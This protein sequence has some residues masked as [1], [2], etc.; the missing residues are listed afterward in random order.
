MTWLLRDMKL[1]SRPDVIKRYAKLLYDANVVG[2]KKLAIKLSKNSQFLIEL[3]IDEDDAELIVEQTEERLEEEWQAKELQRIQLL[4][5]Q[6]QSCLGEDVG[7]ISKT[8]NTVPLGKN[9]DSGDR[10]TIL[11]VTSTSSDISPLSEISVA[12]GI[13]YK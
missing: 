1:E 8:S 13:S 5:Q 3:G 12:A 10:V 4:Q 11:P 7:M 2:Y 6:Q 9:G